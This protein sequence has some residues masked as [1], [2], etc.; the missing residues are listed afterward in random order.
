MEPFAARRPQIA[1]LLGKPAKSGSI[2]SQ[3]F[4]LLR[5]AGVDIAMHLPHTAPDPVPPWLFGADLVVNRGLSLD[6]LIAARRLEDAG[7]RCC[8]HIR[9]TLAV[10]DRALVVRRLVGAGLPVPATVEAATWGDLLAAAAGPS[11]VVKTVDGS[12]G[13]GEGVLIAE[14]DGLPDEAPFA[15]PYLIQHRIPADGWDRKLYLA[16]DHVSGLLKP[17]S[18]RTPDA[19]SKPFSPD[20]MLVDL[21]RRVAATLDLDVCGV[22]IVVGPGGPMVVDVNPFPGFKG[23]PNAACHI[24]RHL[25]YALRASDAGLNLN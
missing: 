17:W 2:F 11:V 24:A 4:E 16:G 13:R 3:L 1:F 20:S 19:I 10:R 8:N 23:V 7:V 6:A 15:G 22:D 18:R 9:A 5:A 21:S 14:P 25:T 12:L